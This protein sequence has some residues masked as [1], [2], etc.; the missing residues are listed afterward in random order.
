MNDLSADKL[1][2]LFTGTKNRGIFFSHIDI[3][4]DADTPHGLTILSET[5]TWPGLTVIAY[6][7]MSVALTDKIAHAFESALIRSGSA[8]AV[9]KIL[10]RFLF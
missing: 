6:Q 5:K 2:N 4:R 8:R 1:L 3:K 7:P 10:T 9:K